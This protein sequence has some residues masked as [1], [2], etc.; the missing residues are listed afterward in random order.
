MITCVL[1]VSRL[2]A[3]I[4]EAASA[5]GMCVSWSPPIEDRLK[6]D[7]NEMETWLARIS[8][9]CQQQAEAHKVVQVR[10]PH[11]S[12]WPSQLRILHAYMYSL[13]AS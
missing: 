4:A 9:A 13:Q 12:L 2:Q 6:E 10:C 11:A 3:M 8:L 1:Q 5:L 7:F